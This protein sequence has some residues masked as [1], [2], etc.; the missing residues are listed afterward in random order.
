VRRAYLDHASTS[1]LRPAAFEAMLP[2]LRDHHADPGR[3]HA[4]GRVT[5]VA[6]EDAR[7]QVATLLGARPREVVFTSSGTEAVNTAV[8]GAVERADAPAHIVTTAVEHS[9]VLEACRRSGAEVAVVGV[10]RLGR[11]DPATA[12][13]ALRPDT[14]LVSVQLAN[15]EVG[16]IQPAGAVVAACRERGVLVHVDACMAAG[17]VPVDFGALDAD[18]CS[19]SAH[20]FGGPKG[21]GAL[22]VRRGLR[23]PP[24]VVG[25]AQERARRGGLEDV[26]AMISFGAAAAEVSADG[27]AAEAGAQREL[28]DRVAHDAP[29]RVGGVTLYGDP[30][31]RVPHLVCLGVEGVEAEPI[32]L[33][34]D[35]RGVAVHSGSACSSEALEPSPILA[36]MGVDADHSLRVSVGWSS[37]AEDV[38]AFLDAFPAVVDRLRALRA[39]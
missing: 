7:E 21:A 14:A 18:L 23:L 22:L 11:Y 6:L 16:T 25:G 10:D 19:V 24:F 30:V 5:R 17:H 20:K 27:L 1:P 39:G 26:P 31:D 4:E 3:L 32:L 33:G 37:T 38:D 34:L 13:D 15:H 8:W 9:A 36:A 29:A 28:T 2:F 35:Q 12:L